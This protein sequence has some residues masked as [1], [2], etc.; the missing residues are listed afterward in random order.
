[1]VIYWLA[2]LRKFHTGKVGKP[3]FYNLSFSCILKPNSFHKSTFQLASFF[4]LPSVQLDNIIFDGKLYHVH[5]GFQVDFFHDVVFVGFHGAHTNKQL[6][7]N[8]TVG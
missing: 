6:I 4:Q 7:R 2:I 5:R 3:H 8:G 1:M